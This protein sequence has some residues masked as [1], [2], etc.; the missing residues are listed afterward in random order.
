MSLAR[1]ISHREGPTISILPEPMTLF[2]AHPT[3]SLDST[4]QS[5]WSLLLV[6]LSSLSFVTLPRSPPPAPSSVL[7]EVRPAE[8]SYLQL[9]MPHLAW[10]PWALQLPYQ[11]LFSFNCLYYPRGRLPLYSLRPAFLTVS[12]PLR[13]V[14]THELCPLVTGFYCTACTW[15]LPFRRVIISHQ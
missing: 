5:R 2:S 11:S 4:L 7:T 14:R 10:H 3:E 9:L 8:P 12:I 1:L 15:L 6:T 13:K